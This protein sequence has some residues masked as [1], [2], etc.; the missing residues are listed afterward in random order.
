MTVATVVRHRS[1]CRHRPVVADR[2]LVCAQM[3]Q[4]TCR[5][6]ASTAPGRY[7]VN[8]R[9]PRFSARAPRRPRR[10]RGDRGGSREWWPTR[11]MAF[12]S[13]GSNGRVPA[14]TSAASCIHWVWSWIV[15]S[16]IAR[17]SCLYT[18]SN[19]NGL[20]SRERVESSASAA[21]AV[22]RIRQARKILAREGLQ[23]R[24][25]RGAIVHPL[26]RLEVAMMSQARQLLAELGLTTTARARLGV[27]PPLTRSSRSQ[28]SGP[29]RECP[30]RGDEG[31]STREADD[32]DQGP[33][34]DVR[35]C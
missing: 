2:W 5:R 18:S 22:G 24:S 21:V 6:F 20:A 29:R 31:G 11:S 15:V 32:R 30:L 1:T 34:L 23:A 27:S 26:G 12:E 33:S 35:S 7:V 3:R 28:R 25:E 8:R 9:T 10:A 17:S 14:I 4:T 13:S 16:P 19:E